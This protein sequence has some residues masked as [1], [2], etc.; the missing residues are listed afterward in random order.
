MVLLKSV[1]AA[2]GLFF[3]VKALLECARTEPDQCK[4][5]NYIF[6]SI[7]WALLTIALNNLG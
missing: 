2:V 3:A 1:T 7:T 6:M 5:S 4:R